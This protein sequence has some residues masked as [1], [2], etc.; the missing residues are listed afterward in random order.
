MF[1]AY[2]LV[3]HSTL[4]WRV[5][6]KK[7]GLKADPGLLTKSTSVLVNGKIEHV[8]KKKT[9][10]IFPQ[11]VFGIRPHNKFVGPNFAHEL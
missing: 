1:K 2:R 5:M 11:G 3:R 7:K 10:I 8:L 4:G 9:D 6:K